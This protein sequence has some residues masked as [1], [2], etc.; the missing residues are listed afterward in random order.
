MFQRIP[1]YPNMSSTKG[2][3]YDLR[4]QNPS[5]ATSKTSQGQCFPSENLDINNHHPP[6]EV[7]ED[8]PQ[9]TMT[10]SSLSSL[11]RSR[12]IPVMSMK[13]FQEVQ[14][15]DKLDLLMATINKIN[16]NF[17]FKFEDLH[18]ELE[19]TI[20]GVCN[21]VLPKVISLEKTCEEMQARLEDMEGA[22][23]EF[24][25]VNI[26]LQ[27]IDDITP[28][29]ENLQRCVALVES[30]QEAI[31]DSLAT[32]KGFVQVLDKQSHSNKAKIV[33]LTARSMAQNVLIY[34][35][36]P[37][38]DRENSKQVS[39]DFLCTKMQMELQDDE[40]LVDHRL[41]KKNSG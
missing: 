12:D 19:S 23:P 14:L 6:S 4:M 8:F 27:K 16:T 7:L 39:L 41:G 18:K 20:K 37:E 13:Y 30:S 31:K 34:G 11:T 32:V 17:H 38:G 5:Q 26:K 2:I 25:E 33:D 10:D 36:Y 9:S 15:D 35:L 40:V 1:I 21:Y 29:L 3:P 28:K 24:K 22:I